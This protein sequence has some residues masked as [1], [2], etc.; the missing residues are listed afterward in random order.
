MPPCLW[1]GGGGE[2]RSRQHNR[3]KPSKTPPPKPQPDMSDERVL[4]T[5]EGATN[6]SPD[7]LLAKNADILPLA[8]CRS[9]EE[10]DETAE[11]G[12]PSGLP[13]HIR[14]CV[15][16]DLRTP[17][18]FASL[19]N[20]D[21]KGN[22]TSTPHKSRRPRPSELPPGRGGGVPARAGG[23]SSSS[24]DSRYISAAA[25]RTSEFIS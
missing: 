23:A 11:N 22:T 10:K 14:I 6:V 25:V 3:K 9:G 13:P 21:H 17:C 12:P 7:K 2:K 8:T 16:P 19:Q 4:R 1:A 15:L 18:A 5:L 20:L 24:K